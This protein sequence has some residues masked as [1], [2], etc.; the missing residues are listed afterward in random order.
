MNY[1]IDGHNL[2]PHIPGLS[3]SDLDDEPSLI[4]ML[5]EYCRLTR[6]RAELYFDGAPPAQKSAQGGG[7][8]RVHFV[9]KGTSADDAI[10]RSLH[11]KGTSVRNDSLVSSDHRIQAEARVVGMTVIESAEFARR[12]VNVLSSAQS[13]AGKVEPT[14]TPS[15]VEDWLQRFSADS[16]KDS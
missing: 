8:V 14:L 5:Q 10:I 6:S 3:L 12:M 11:Q 7:L 2:I 9:R 1:V 15:E 4:S 13:A 16:G